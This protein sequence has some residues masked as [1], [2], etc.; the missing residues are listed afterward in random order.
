MT[1]DSVKRIELVANIMLSQYSIIL[2]QPHIS[3]ILEL[4]RILGV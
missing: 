1:K 3:I 4:S 2:N